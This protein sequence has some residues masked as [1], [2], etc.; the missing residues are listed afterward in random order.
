MK[1]NP[2][3]RVSEVRLVY[4]S[5]IDIRDRPKVRSS[6]DAYNVFINNWSDQIELVEEFNMLMLRRSGRVL[7][8]LNVSKGGHSGTIVD[9]KIIFSAALKCCANSIILA[10]NH[11]SGQTTPSRADNSLTK[12]LKQAGEV[13]DILV[14]DHLIITPYSYYSYGDEGLL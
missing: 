4:K 13:L 12:K 11:P 8:I 1:N 7:G 3:F 5:K 14:I 9:A 6:R 10:H 2:L